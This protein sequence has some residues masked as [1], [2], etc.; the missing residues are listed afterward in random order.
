MELALEIQKF[1]ESFDS[2]IPQTA[3]AIDGTYI[4]INSSTGDSKIDY[5]N[6]RKRRYSISTPAVVGGILTFLDIATA[7][8]GQYP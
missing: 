6:R 1:Q 7:Y 3:G 2:K 5:F 4:E 8:P